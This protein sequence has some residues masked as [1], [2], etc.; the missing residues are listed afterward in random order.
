MNDVS[1]RGVAWFDTLSTRKVEEFEKNLLEWA[2]KN[3]QDAVMVFDESCIQPMVEEIREK[4]KKDPEYSFDSLENLRILKTKDIY[5]RYQKLN[6]NMCVIASLRKMM[7][8]THGFHKEFLQVY[9]LPS[10]WQGCQ[11]WYGF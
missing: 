4:A 11:I 10:K 9:T 7:D 1:V 8:S 5:L 6:V 3:G 2:T